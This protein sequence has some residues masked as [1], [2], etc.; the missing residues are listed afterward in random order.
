VDDRSF[1]ILHDESHTQDEPCSQLQQNPKALKGILGPMQ[2][3]VTDQE[4]NP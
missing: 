3:E 1:P 2:R 4:M